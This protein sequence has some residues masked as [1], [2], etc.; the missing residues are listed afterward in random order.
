MI[1]SFVEKSV[2]IDAIKNYLV[3]QL[4]ERLKEL[5]GDYTKLTA[6]EK[7][8]L[9]A[10]FSELWNPDTYRKGIY[11]ISGWVIDFTEWTKTFWVKTKYHGIIE[12]RSFSKTMVRKC[13]CNP[14]DIIKIVQID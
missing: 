1:Y 2:P 13:S 14:N 7:E 5:N 9:F 3:Y 8:R 6:E 4:H 10:I 12:V 11:R